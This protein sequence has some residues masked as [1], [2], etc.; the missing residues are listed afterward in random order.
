MPNAKTELLQ[1]SYC[2]MYFDSRIKNDGRLEIQGWE[3]GRKEKGKCVSNGG[4]KAM[5]NT[6]CMKELER[7]N[8]KGEAKEKMP[9]FPPYQTHPVN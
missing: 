8:M 3:Y 7:I 4:A 5:A 6:T 1:Q 2:T 9:Y